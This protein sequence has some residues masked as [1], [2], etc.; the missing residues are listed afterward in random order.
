MEKDQFNPGFLVIEGNIGSGKTTLASLLAEKFNAQLLLEQFAENPFLSDFYQNPR[1]YAF[2][3][4]MSFMAE[5]FSQLRRELQNR[6]L[7]K[8]FIVSDYYFMKSL[9]FAGVTLSHDEYALYRKFFEIVYDRLPKPGLYVYLH[10]EPV[11][12]KRNIIKRGRI[13]EQDIEEDYLKKITE[14]YFRY[15]QQQ[16]EFPVLVIDTNNIDFVNNSD[17]FNTICTV[18]FNQVYPVGTTRVII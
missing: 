5:R 13:Y 11:L 18:L 15:F 8:D 2:T 14:A 3:L 10:K 1:Q 7:F 9:I 4:E 17:D 6:D 12:L 16:T